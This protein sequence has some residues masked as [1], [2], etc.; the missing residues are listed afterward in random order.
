MLA[1]VHIEK[2][3]GTSLIHILRRNY[4]LKYSDVR[5]LRSDSNGVFTLNDFNEFKK[6]NPRLECISGHAVKPYGDFMAVNNLK[7]ITMLRDPVKRYISQYQQWIDK[8][9]ADISFEEFLETESVSN[10]QTKKIAGSDD[11]ELAKERLNDFFL[12]GALEHFDEFLIML[13]QR[14]NEI[15]FHMA[16]ERRN[17][18]RKSTIQ[19]RLMSEYLSDIEDK[20]KQD[21]ILYKHVVENIRQENRRLYGPEIDKDLEQFKSSNKVTLFDRAKLNID[22]LFRKLYIEPVTGGIRNQNGLKKSGSY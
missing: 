3:A 21:I 14:L 15:N 12:V 16:Y 9:Y 5:P 22:Y 19:K 6:I 1:F 11:V 13:S 10:F 4:F 7:L 8:K 20:N 17:E 2:S 18:S